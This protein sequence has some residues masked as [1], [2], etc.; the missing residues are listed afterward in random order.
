MCVPSS[1]RAVQ[2]VGRRLTCVALFAAMTGCSS[3]PGSSILSG[4]SP[5]GKAERE[6]VVDL[7]AP[8]SSS[9]PSQRYEV[10]P[11]NA[12]RFEL[13]LAAVDIDDLVAAEKYFLQITK[14]QPELPGPW[15]NLAQIE[16]QRGD[17]EAAG[18]ILRRAVDANPDNCQA[19]T[20][21]G[22]MSREVGD[23]ASAEGYYLDCLQR[24]ADF[25]D[26]HY[27]LGILYEIY[28]G[29]LPEALASYRTYQALTEKPDRRVAGWVMDL[30]R[31]IGGAS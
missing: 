27:N 26:A 25:A 12:E 5:V 21:L 13:G 7:S 15:A 23:F 1:S 8:D 11:R 4:N 19:L 30:E 22:L 28:L 18:S 24:D 31:R 20:S 6:T 16:R 14:D 29:R 2:R 9:Q 17:I 10:A 3:M